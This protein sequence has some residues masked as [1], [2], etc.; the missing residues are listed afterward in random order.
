MHFGKQVKDTSSP[1]AVTLDLGWDFWKLSRGVSSEYHSLYPVSFFSLSL[2]V[3]LN[4][5]VISRWVCTLWCVL[6]QT[7][8]LLLCLK[9][10]SLSGHFWRKL[11]AMLCHY[12]YLEELLLQATKRCLKNQ[13]G[14]ELAVTELT[15]LQGYQ[16]NCCLAVLS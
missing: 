12:K 14:L 3:I 15:S 13:N 5:F 8:I 11:Y 6:E 2:T 1:L 4:I 16:C 7:E 9:G 10:H